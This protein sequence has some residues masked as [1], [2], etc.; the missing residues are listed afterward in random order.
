[1][2]ECFLDLCTCMQKHPCTLEEI[3]LPTPTPSIVVNFNSPSPFVV[4]PKSLGWDLLIIVL[5]LVSSL[6]F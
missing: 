1:M 4:L 2:V 3:L 5:L 6:L